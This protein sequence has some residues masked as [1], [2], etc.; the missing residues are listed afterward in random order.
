MVMEKHNIT[1][2]DV[3]FLKHYGRGWLST[4]FANDTLNPQFFIT[5]KQ[6]KVGWNIVFK[7]K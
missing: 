2:G 7:L 5:L 3:Y 1:K 4:A 6:T